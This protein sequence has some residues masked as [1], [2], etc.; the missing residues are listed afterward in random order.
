MT[1]HRVSGNRKSEPSP[2]AANG[3]CAAIN[4]LDG[5]ESLEDS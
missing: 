2:T 1:K 3:P 5:K 4:S